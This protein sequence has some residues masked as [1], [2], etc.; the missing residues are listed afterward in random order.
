MFKRLLAIFLSLALLISAVP[1]AAGIACIE[2]MKRLDIANLLQKKGEQLKRE[3]ESAAKEYGYDMVV[4]GATSLP[5]LRIAESEDLI[6]HQRWVAECVRR[7]VF[8]TSHHN[9]FMNAAMTDEDIRL[10]GEVARE[11]F[12]IIREG[13]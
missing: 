4:S 9:H 3:L 7:G 11:A 10:T 6:L 8:F 1:F 12:R 2:K 13:K 5:Y